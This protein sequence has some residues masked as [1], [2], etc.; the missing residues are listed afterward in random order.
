MDAGIEEFNS[1][2]DRLVSQEP[3][4]SSATFYSGVALA[5]GEYLETR[6][7]DGTSVL[8]AAGLKCDALSERNARFPIEQIAA[9]FEISS[10]RLN[11]PL[12]GLHFGE[13]YAPPTRIAGHYA[14]NNA[15]DLQEALITVRDY[16]N[17]MVGIPTQL[18]EESAFTELSWTVNVSSFCPRH[19]ND[20]M[21]VR[22][23]NHIQL[24]TGPDW[25]PMK[26]DLASE[27][28]ES[29]SDHFRLLG[30]NIL[31]GQPENVVRVESDALAMPM[32]NA[33]PDLYL[34]ARSSLLNP[35]PLKQDDQDPVD[36]LRRLI[37]VHL[38]K[39]DITLALASENM[40]MTPHQL[41]RLLKKH[42]TC[43]QCLVDDTRK[44]AA[45]YYLLH[46]ELR[47]SEITFLLGFSDQSV[48]TR[49]A[50]RWFGATP[51]QLRRGR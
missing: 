36:R 51:K 25:R 42:G 30:S 1:P 28:P 2:D 6:G 49:A 44:V 35:F 34:V 31:F 19:M 22:T 15:K 12:F 5:L 11:D 21:V 10:Q 9:A 17:Q 20:F 4:E 27:K 38:E 46:S 29:P 16:R 47:F 23:L 39:N 26:V 43:F 33:D 45:E 18:S 41:R 32:P 37:S 13:C 7:Q 48:F 40:S 8:Q 24:A 14:I 3:Q 50:K